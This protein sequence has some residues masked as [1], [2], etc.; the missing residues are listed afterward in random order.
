M[1]LYNAVLMLSFI[2]LIHPSF[3]ATTIVDGTSAHAKLLPLC[4]VAVTPGQS[5]HIHS[6]D[7]ERE[8]LQTGEWEQNGAE[9]PL[10]ASQAGMVQDERRRRDLQAYTPHTLGSSGNLTDGGDYGVD[11]HKTLSRLKSFNPFTRGTTWMNNV[12]ARIRNHR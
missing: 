9:W 3:S 8:F 1:N 2:H 11:S 12:S 7:L 6:V 5:A 4:F 10:E